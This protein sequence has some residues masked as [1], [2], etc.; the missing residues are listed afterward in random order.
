M[1]LLLAGACGPRSLGH[2]Q[3]G[4]GGNV[5]SVS[6][7]NMSAP[8]ISGAGGAA[9]GASGGGSVAVG[10]PGAGGAG[11]GSTG[12]GGARGPNPPACPP[13]EPVLPPS[14][15]HTALGRTPTP[16]QGS[17]QRL[18][19]SFIFPLPGP[20]TPGSNAP[21]L[22]VRCASFAVGAAQQLAFSP[23]GRLVALVPEDGIVRVVEIAS[24]MIVATL[25]PVRTTID[26]AAFSPDGLA[27]VTLASG[28]REVTLW[29]AA[30]A[31]FAKT[32]SVQLTG[33]RYQPRFGGGGLAVS[34]D[35]LS[36]LVSAGQETFLLGATTGAV[37]AVRPS[38]GALLR[39][40]Y[41]WGG[42]RIVV[43]D[44]PTA[45]DCA[46]APSGGTVT[47][48]DAGT[49]SDVAQV[50]DLGG[51]FDPRGNLGLA[52]FVA[53][54][55]D[56]LV[57]VPGSVGQPAGVRAFRLSDGTPAPSPALSAL[58]Y[59]FMPDGTHVLL[60]GSGQLSV[61]SAGDGS[62]AASIAD[63]GS[64]P[65]AISP[66][67][68]SVAIGG[69]GPQ[70]LRVW[71]VGDAAPA[72][73]CAGDDPDATAPTVPGGASLSADGQTIAIGEGPRARLF[74][75]A[76]GT[77]L[78]SFD[79]EDASQGA[80][81]LLSASPLY[82]ATGPSS[83]SAFPTVVFN[84][85]NSGRVADLPPQGTRWGD[86]AF[87]PAED[88]LYAIGH[89]T[90]AD[91]LYVATLGTPGLTAVAT[92]Q[93]YTSLLGFAQGC[94]VLYQSSRGA[95]RACGTCADPPVGGPGGFAVL[96]PDGGLLARSA[97]FPGPNVT[98][99]PMQPG[100][101]QAWT[102]GP[103]PVDVLYGP[104]QEIPIAIARGGGRVVT[105]S[106]PTTTCYRG[107]GLE[108]RVH[109]QT[110]GTVMDTLPPAPTAVDATVRTI[111][112]GAQLW[113]SVF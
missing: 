31:S 88:R 105:T 73:V 55:T 72:A 107:P 82:L 44:A 111:A 95:W 17:C 56:D 83:A 64:A 93:D 99:M 7:P 100:T 106:S 94:P 16:A 102:Y 54:P 91:R 13:V 25:A 9:G 3:D 8:A 89:G 57:L 76:T 71:N 61:A 48:L 35:G 4:G 68:H 58:P 47:I 51:K 11:V 5:G 2:D 84:V 15:P 33:H 67:G 77:P 74:S 21:G 53:S 26:F 62:I 52:N 87:S 40:A 104:L 49:L 23:D 43:A 112:Y 39:L 59:A 32:W 65:V 6:P 110:S 75:T 12:T 46:P 41:G 18:G 34:P 60:R 92:L 38:K 66:D 78:R 30:G 20:A 80:R 22:F 14:P 19:S 86:L 24:H 63:D 101:T 36:V 37:Q 27:I 108:V 90:D 45:S 98:L 97:P 29:S 85:N 70:L 109:D 96:S 42:R 1:P 28:A 79:L 113:C 10:G 50:A 103:S 81:L 69:R